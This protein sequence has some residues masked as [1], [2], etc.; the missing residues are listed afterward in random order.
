MHPRTVLQLQWSM[1]AGSGFCS[2]EII[3]LQ[4]CKKIGS[5]VVLFSFSVHQMYFTA[6]TVVAD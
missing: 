6:C 1:K 5:I 2:L 3:I 4:H